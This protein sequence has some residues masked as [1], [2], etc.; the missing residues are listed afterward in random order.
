V[1]DESIKVTVRDG[2]ITLDGAVDWQYQKEEAGRAGRQL[3]GARGVTN[4]I[5]VKPRA[6][7]RQEPKDIEARIRE[8][9]LRSAILDAKSIHVDTRNGS[10]ILRGQVHSHMER[11]DA[12]RVAWTVAGV[13]KV[14]NYITI[15]PW[16]A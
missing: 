1:P 14:E 10:V 7:S 5:I 6:G 13:A 12:E 2:W 9:F 11:D 4:S 15:A 8:A 3:I 16:E